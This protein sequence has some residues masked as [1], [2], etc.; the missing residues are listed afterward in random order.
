[1]PTYPVGQ[2]ILQLS[3]SYSEPYQLRNTGLANVYIGRDTT[4]SALRHDWTLV[5]NDTQIFDGNSTVYITC[6]FGRTSL[7]DQLY[8]ANSGFIPGAI[9]NR[10]NS[11]P[12][13][14]FNAPIVQFPTS[15]TAIASYR[16]PVIDVADF[17]TIQ[18]GLSAGTDTSNTPVL[19][20]YMLV[21]VSFY[22][23]P[24]RGGKRANFSCTFMLCS[25]L[26]VQTFTVPVRAQYMELIV[27]HNR[28]SAT[29]TTQTLTLS[30]SGGFVNLNVPIYESSAQ[31]LITDNA[32]LY[33]GA[34]IYNFSTLGVPQAIATRSGDATLLF[35]DGTG[36]VSVG[37]VRD[38]LNILFIA[39]SFTPNSAQAI[40]LPFYPVYIATSVASGTPVFSLVLE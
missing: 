9:L 7:V 2:E 27:T 22:D 26:T 24:A 14:F 4:V 12:V 34:T 33:S 29:A 38:G 10:N 36:G 40:K 1:M 28:A 20:N 11:V 18:I 16:H 17:S 25:T 15:P 19:G 6:A 37:V 32:A 5:P 39:T 13:M 8:G 35:S 30:L 23:D 31:N 3:G 21:S